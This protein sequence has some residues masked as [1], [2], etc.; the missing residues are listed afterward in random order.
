MNFEFIGI[1]ASS[2]VLCSAIFNSADIKRNILMR[3]LNILGS[4]C[5]VIYGFIIISPSII[6]LNTA[7][8]IV[9][10]NYTFK[11]SKQIKKIKKAPTVETV[12]VWAN[13]SDDP[14]MEHIK[15]GCL[16]V[17]WSGSYGWGRWEMIM[18]EKGLP[19]IYSEHMDKGG[20]KEFSKAILNKVLEVAIVE[21]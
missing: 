10:L 17:D 11:L 9:C 18:D 21:D 3:L 13:R 2:I 8:I 7:M 12:D 20:D 5:F 15:Y 16:G 14:K 1:I 6:I 19:H 4:I